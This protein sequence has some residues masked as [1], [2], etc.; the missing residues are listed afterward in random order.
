MSLVC[1]IR[2]FFVD[3][4][5]TQ[6]FCNLFELL[7]LKIN[8]IQLTPWSCTDKSEVATTW[9]TVVSLLQS[10][11]ITANSLTYGLKLLISSCMEEMLSKYEK[12]K[13]K[14]IW[15]EKTESNCV[16]EL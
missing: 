11:Q 16:R 13:K 2:I 3:M 1:F 6:W 14:V 4:F 15:G 9:R 7:N 8:S 12:Q 5:Y 10:W